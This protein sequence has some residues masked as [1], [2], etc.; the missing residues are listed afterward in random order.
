MYPSDEFAINEFY[1]RLYFQGFTVI[2]IARRYLE[3]QYLTLVI[4][5]QTQLKAIE[6]TQRAFTTQCQPFEN[7]VHVDALIP[8][9]PQQGAVHEA[10]SGT[11]AKQT[12]LYED[13]ELYNY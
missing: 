1:E 13:D 12:F 2:D 9:H 5:N 10:Y 8:A 11:F 3:V 4:V 6:P 7:L